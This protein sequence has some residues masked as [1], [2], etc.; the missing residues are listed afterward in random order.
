M[1]YFEPS[2]QRAQECRRAMDEALWTSVRSVLADRA[3]GGLADP[4]AKARPTGPLDYGAYFDLVL[5][6]PGLAELPDEVREEATAYLE[7][8]LPQ[9]EGR[10][11]RGDLSTLEM[12]EVTNLS[13]ECYSPAQIDRFRRWWDIEPDNAMG[14]TGVSV[15]EFDAAS[16]LL[17]T[18]LGHLRGAA[19]DLHG[20]VLALVS[21]IVMAR[22]D[23]SQRMDYGG[24]T[25]FSLWGAFA[26][27]STAHDGW[28]RYYRT[29]VH[30]T[31]HNLLFA[32]ARDEPLV[33][34]APEDRHVSPLRSDLRP[35]DGIFHAAF[36]SARESLA[37]DLLLCRHEKTG[38]LSDQEAEEFNDLLETSVL[39]FTDCE[40]TLRKD[41]RLTPLGLAILD[42]CASYMRSNFL[43]EAL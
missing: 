21:D 42:E 20:E 27:N 41:A 13:Q 17:A 16:K 34:D 29:L 24:A 33:G 3:G 25:S 14:L 19:P 18:A 35:M 5:P 6:P 38:C 8:R 23:G 10:P 12:P 11:S 31:G 40:T 39:A 43:V 22:P 26:I 7:R 15:D 28:P 32:M 37:F 9:M 30:E 1:T 4:A 2:V 36:V